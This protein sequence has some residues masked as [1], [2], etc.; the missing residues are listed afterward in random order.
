MSELALKL[1]EENRNTKAP[2]LDLSNCGMTEIPAQLT[3]LLWLEELF[4]AGDKYYDASK[5]EFIQ[6]KNKE[7]KN[8]CSRLPEKFENLQRL[9]KIVIAGD[10]YQKHSLSG[11]TSLGHL[12]NLTYLTIDYTEISSLAALRSLKALRGLS[13][14]NNQISNLEPLS[15]LKALQ[16]L[17]LFNNQI[18]SLDPLR[19][20]QRL[21]ELYLDLNQVSSLAPL[22]NLKTLRDLH[23]N[24][25]QVSEIEPI[26]GLSRL[27]ELYFSNNRVDNIEPLTGLHRLQRLSFDNN[28]VTKLEPLTHIASLLLFHCL[29]CPVADCPADVYA[30]GDVQ[31]LK[32]HYEGKKTEQASSAKEKSSERLPTGGD[33][34]RDVK[35]IILGNSNAGKTNLVQYLG[36]QRYSG[37]RDSTHGLEVQRW[38]PDEVLYPE[39]CDIAVSIW[40][41]G[42][43]EYYHDVYRLFL[44]DNAVYLLLWCGE[45]DKN[46]RK[47]TRLRNEEPEVELEYF[48]INYWLDTIK[49][50]SGDRANSLLLAVQNKVDDL[51]RANGQA[52]H[53]KKRIDQA[54][55]EKYGIHESYHISLKEGSKDK[56]SRQAK[57]LQHF[58]YELQDGLKNSA[59][60]SPANRHWQ[61]IRNEV[62]ALKQEGK[63][64]AFAPYLKQDLWISLD[65]FKKGCNEIVTAPLSESEAAAIPV[66]LNQGGSV[67]YSPD[68]P[69]LRDKIFLRPDRLAERIYKV[70]DKEVLPRDGEFSEDDIM[71]DASS[72]QFRPVFL[73]LAQQLNLIFPHPDPQKKGKQF[74]APQY[75]PDSHPIEDLFRIASRDAWQNGLWVKVPLFYYRK[76]LHGL[77]LHYAAD[78]NCRCRYYW[79]H[80]IMF[81]THAASE[82]A[83]IRVLIKGL[84]PQEDEH[85]GILLLGVE[86]KGPQA[87]DLQREIF[88]KLLQILNEKGASKHPKD[89]TAGA[90]REPLE[91]HK[92]EESTFVQLTEELDVPLFVSYDGENYVAYNDIKNTK[93]PKVKADPSEQKRPQ[94]KQSTDNPEKTAEAG[95]VPKTDVWLITQKF[96]AVL[97]N[98]PTRAKKVF[99]SYSHQ[100]T[101]WLTRL[102]TH[103]AGLRRN[104]IIE[105][106]DDKE[107]LPGDQWD[108]AI[109]K[110]LEEADVYIMLLSADFIA[111]EYIWR[112]E[113]Q[114]ALHHYNKRDA[115][116]I[117]VLFEP[118]DLGGLPALI[119]E[120]GRELK[121]GDLEI[122]PKNSNQMLQAVSLWQNQ[123]EALAKVAERIRE[124]IT[125]K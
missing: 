55:H 31:L 123:E 74:I 89:V 44:S 73:E 107:I 61:L 25:N 121:I 119:G 50:Y 124:A 65:D 33:T 11:I 15:D 43:Q 75:L 70:L 108:T 67:K 59:D 88:K 20:L 122:L 49:H 28:Q 91:K 18:I 23:F 112:E 101:A 106:W 58:L 120:N 12:H 34:K 97:D 71:A 90:G 26:R 115:K 5:R 94:P 17:S 100:N 14:R 81:L 29:G 113:L 4:I 53:F 30:R 125:K 68:V 1:I 109:K 22:K 98:K 76:I 32:A 114:A 77:L 69:F 79:K 57:T 72:L 47:K 103:L 63:E 38:V 3:E 40:D 36:T 118:L 16:W 19:N 93:E 21:Q 66:W 116:I 105:I 54:L 80:G 10:V 39:L 6:T 85:Q 27:Q 48:D 96:E 7:K 62:L 86:N 46:F 24:N 42:G 56:E 35:L 9:W 95:T 52:A 92:D 51:D 45:S 111:S 37:L 78:G 2:T 87:R 82:E 83:V 99:L 117:A 60:K 104:S 64:N 13:L 110:Q 41:F 102:R 8:H 84:Y